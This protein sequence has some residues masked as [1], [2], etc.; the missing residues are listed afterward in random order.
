MQSLNDLLGESQIFANREVLS[1]HYTPHTLLYREREINNIEKALAPSLKGE[2][3]RNLFIYGRTGTGKTSCVKYVMDEVKN[4]TNIRAKL[5]YI[6][7]RLYNSRFRVLNKIISDHLSTYA[8]RGYGAVDLYEKIASWIEEDNKILVVILDEIDVVKDLDD[9]IYTLTRINSD[10]KAGGVTIIGISNK[11]SFKDE[12]DPRSLSTLYETELVF[13]PYYA[14]EL[15][16]ILKDRANMGFKKDV[17]DD[18]VIHYIS[19]ISAKEGGDARFSLKILTKAGEIAEEKH[20]TKV[21]KAEAEEAVRIIQNEAVYEVISTLP[22]H[23]KI[24]LYAIT[25]LTNSGG[26]YK[27]LTDGNDTYLFS[28]EVYNRYCSLAESIKKEPKS[29]RW[30]RKYLSELEMQGLIVSFESGKGIRGHTKLIKLLYPANKIK[31]A[32]EKQIFGSDIVNEI[33]T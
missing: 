23:Q 3:G 17:V 24:V 12:L 9:L 29:E 25:L 31:E 19:A 5:S 6:N 28:G 1:P 30:Y 11:V 7:C 26:T 14:T 18:E 21:T 8:K 20:M 15:Y 4:L 22:E 27:K 13:A 16:A 33:E 32:L 10:I 2:K